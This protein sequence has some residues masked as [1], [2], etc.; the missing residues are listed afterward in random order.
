VLTVAGS[1]SSGGAGIQAD[2]KTFHALGVPGLTVITALTSQN[3]QGVTQIHVTPLKH[4][5]GQLDAVDADFNIVAAKTGMM[6]TGGIISAAA[7]FFA[8]RPQIKLVVDPVLI[9]TSGAPLCLE[10]TTKALIRDLIPLGSLVTPNMSEA[11]ALADANETNGE[12]LARRLWNL[13]HVPF[14]VK[15]GH[16]KGETVRDVLIADGRTRI[17]TSPRLPGEHHGTGCILSSAIAAHLVKGQALPEAVSLGR[18]FL[19]QALRSAIRPGNAPLNYL[20]MA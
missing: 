5:T 18:K 11:Q 13:F 1:D 17:F 8:S 16:G 10:D 12:R 3:S 4:L 2:L 9:S 14:L 7:K 19:Q 20:L 15:G 6:P